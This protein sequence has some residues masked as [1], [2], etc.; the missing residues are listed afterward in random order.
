MKG[1]NWRQGW[2][3]GRGERGMNGERNEGE[4]EE[5]AKGCVCRGIPPRE[6]GRDKRTKRKGKERCERQGLD[7]AFI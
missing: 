2:R 7:R 1:C 3:F 5:G 4:A 6:L